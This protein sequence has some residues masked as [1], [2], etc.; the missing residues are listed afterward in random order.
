MEKMFGGNAQKIFL[1]GLLFAV[2]AR[3]LK[4]DE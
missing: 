1:S 4:I 3:I 2:F